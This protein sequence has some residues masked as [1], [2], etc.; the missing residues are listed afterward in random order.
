[1]SSCFAPKK[2]WIV[3]RLWV[4]LTHWLVARNWNLAICGLSFTALSVW[5]RVL[6]STPL[7]AG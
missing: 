3:E 2:P 6:T 7:R 4:P 5:N 1:M